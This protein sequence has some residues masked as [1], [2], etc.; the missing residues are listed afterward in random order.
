M[1]K[2]VKR[3]LIAEDSFEWQ[4][5]HASLLKQY[6]KC[7]FEFVVFDNAKD[8][9]KN[10]Q[11]SVNNLYDLIITDLQM[12][13]DFLPEFAGEWFVKQVKN[14]S[15]YKNAHI[16]IVSAAY[17][18]AFIAHSL[19]VGYLS[20]RSLVNNPDSYFLMLDENIL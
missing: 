2:I 8:A 19:G 4:R 14:I 10:L 12:E 6:D 17:N 16:V 15:E 9:L 5:F 3:I 11:D 20:K 18:I 1:S 7:D 13:T